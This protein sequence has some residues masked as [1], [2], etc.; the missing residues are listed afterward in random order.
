MKD[1]IAPQ[2]KEIVEEDTQFVI[3]KKAKGAL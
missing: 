2:D 3:K 1:K